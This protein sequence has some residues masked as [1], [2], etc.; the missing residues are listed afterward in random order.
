MY[1]IVIGGGMVG[2]GLVRQLME[3][4][5]DTVLIEKDKELCDAVYA[6]TGVIAIQGT[7]MLLLLRAATTR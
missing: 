1:V 5:H 2:G 3:N 7:Q 6:E 4:K